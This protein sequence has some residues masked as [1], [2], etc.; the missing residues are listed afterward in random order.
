MIQKQR[1]TE[2][3]VE[4]EGILKEYLF[5]KGLNDSVLLKILIKACDTPVGK[6]AVIKIPNNKVL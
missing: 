1:R 3:T 5:P 2:N 4:A 6:D